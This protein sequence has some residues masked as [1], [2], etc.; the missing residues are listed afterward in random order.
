FLRLG[1]L[2]L[3]DF[4]SPLAQARPVAAPSG[5]AKACILVYLLGGPPHLDMWDLK[6]EAPAEV[7]GP[8]RPISTS[9]PGLSICE[10]LPGL[11]QQAGRYSLVRSVTHPNHNH[12]HMIYYTLTGRHMT[13]PNPN[14]NV[15]NP[16]SRGDHPHLG[17]V[18]GRFKTP[19]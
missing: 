19:E 8:F 18:I 5:R 2:V 14:D 15:P 7:R 16:P 3:A 13:S 10:H 9:L 12:T 6:P 17:S 4:L 11:A 1:G